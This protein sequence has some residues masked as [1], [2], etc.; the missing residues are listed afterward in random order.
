MTPT[1]SQT[2]TPGHIGGKNFLP[3]LLSLFNPQDPVSH[4]V[5]FLS[6]IMPPASFRDEVRLMK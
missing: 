4:L 2:K 3:G 6:S 1:R 5:G